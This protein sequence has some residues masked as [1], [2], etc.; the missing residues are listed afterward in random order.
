MPTDTDYMRRAYTLAL[1]GKGAT[2]PNP[3]VGSVIVKDHRI[4]AEGWHQRCGADH[5]EIN[6]I[7]KAKKT[8]KGATMY[9]TLEPC[10]HFGRTPPCVDQII[11]KR[12]KKVVIGMRDPNPRTNGKS[13]TKLRRAGIKTKVGVLQNEIALMN[14]AFVCYTRKHRPFVTVKCAQT[15]DGKIATASGESKWI[16][17]PEARTYAR[18]VRD[19]H[20]AIMTGI[21]TVLRDDPKL[22]GHKKGKRIKK[23][24]LDSTLRIP[25]NARLFLGTK[26]SD[27]FIATTGKG[28]KK[29]SAALQARGVVVITCPSRKGQIDLRWLFKELAKH[30]ITSVLIEGGAHVV[31][32]A[33]KRKLADKIYVYVAPKIIGDQKALSAIVGINAKQLNRA[34]NL[35]STEIKRLGKDILITGYV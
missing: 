9:V 12:I 14:E 23:I 27:C 21:T 17:S 29:K 22:S 32:D 18:K 8:L 30:E 25:L 34:V 19:E 1:K 6:A 10:N 33:I 35:K 31:G 15:L 24:I 13:I 7:K 16:T 11:D 28:S 3:M 20:D 5:A 26:P 2:S 4:I